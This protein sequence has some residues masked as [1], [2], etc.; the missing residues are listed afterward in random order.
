MAGAEV[1]KRKREGAERGG[2]ERRLLQ[3]Q[4]A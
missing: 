4:M 1:L 3:I 2:Q